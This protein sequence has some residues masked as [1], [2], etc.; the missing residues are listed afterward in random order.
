MN[1]ISSFNIDDFISI[2]DNEWIE[3]DVGHPTLI[4][5]LISKGRN[6][7][8]KEHWVTKYKISYSN[9]SVFWTYYKDAN[10]LEA[11][12]NNEKKNTLNLSFYFWD[13]NKLA[14]Q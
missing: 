13:F 2:E 6:D 3:L 10:H 8:K 9:D 1:I 12:V 11:K 5:G 14:I 7:I 4:T